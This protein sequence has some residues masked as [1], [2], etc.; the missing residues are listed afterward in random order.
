MEWTTGFAFQFT[1]SH[2]LLVE[3]RDLDIHDTLAFDTSNQLGKVFVNRVSIGFYQRMLS[4]GVTGAKDSIL[5]LV[6]IETF[7]VLH[8]DIAGLVL[9]FHNEIFHIPSFCSFIKHYRSSVVC[10]STT[11]FIVARVMYC[12]VINNFSYGFESCIVFQLGM[13]QFCRFFVRFLVHYKWNT[14]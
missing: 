5:G 4:A 6:V 12:T 1:L 11:T 14:H 13:L 9:I 7:Y 3:I 2:K 10:S 8:I